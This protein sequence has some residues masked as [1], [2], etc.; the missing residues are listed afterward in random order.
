M[1]SLNEHENYSLK[2]Y[3][4]KFTELHEWMDFPVRAFGRKHRKFR[5]DPKKTPQ[6]TKRLFGENGDHACLDH[7]VMDL[8]KENKFL[9]KQRNISK[10]TQV[11]TARIPI[12]DYRRL[13]EY[14]SFLDKNKTSMIIEFIRGGLVR[15]SQLALLKQWKIEREKNYHV[16]KQMLL[17]NP[18]EWGCEKCNE[19][20]ALIYYIDGNIMNDNP[21]NMVFLCRKCID[22]LRKFMR[23]HN[24]TEWFAAWFFF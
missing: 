18:K 17:K 7:I 22:K 13:T 2:K 23:R 16:I 11:I 24:P 6:E 20:R 19:E 1:P 3:G 10:Q 4:K 5:H 8:S 14:C 15:H 9:K 12:A 21:K